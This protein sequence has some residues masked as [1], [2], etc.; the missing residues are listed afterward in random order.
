MDND[1]EIG[2]RDG[3]AVQMT[4]EVMCKSQD[5]VC[6]TAVCREEGILPSPPRSAAAEGDENC[7]VCVGPGWGRALLAVWGPEENSTLW[8]VQRDITSLS[9]HARCPLLITAALFVCCVTRAPRR[10][11]RAF[12]FST[13]K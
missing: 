5:E 8:S 4:G 2:K 12:V 13:A 11:L 1:C 6:I 3:R 7:E 9:V 10:K